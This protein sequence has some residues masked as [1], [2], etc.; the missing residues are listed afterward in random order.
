MGGVTS[1]V[2]VSGA[3]KSRDFQATPCVPLVVDLDGTLIKS[4]LLLETASQFA[5]AW[6]SRAHKLAAWL[7][8]GKTVL[9]TNLAQNTRLDFTS[10][11]Y[12]EELLAWL[13]Q[14]KAQGRVIV[15]ATA[16]D[17]LLANRVASHLGLFSEVLASDL[18]TNLKATAKCAA[19]VAK[20]GR[21]GF[22]YV[23]NDWADIEVWKSAAQAHVVSRSGR[24]IK[25]ASS[26]APLG[27]IFSDGKPPV[28]L[29]L[30]QALRPQQW[31]KNL[32][33][34]I[35]LLTA[36]LYSDAGS[37][38]QALLGSTAFCLTASSAYLLNDMVDVAHDRKHA[39]KRHRPFAAGHLSLLYGWLAWPMLLISAF[40]LSQAALPRP[41]TLS[42]GVYFVLT[43]A[44]SLHLKTIPMVDVLMLASLYTLRIIAGAMAIGVPL[45]FW[46][47]SFSMFLFLSLAL[48]KRNGE[49]RAVSQ[50]GKSKNVNGRGYDRDDLELVR[51]L[52]VSA[53]Y[54]S[55][56][57]L[58]LYVQDTHTASLYNTPQFLWLAC[59]LLLFW[60][61][62]AWLISHRGQMHDDP[63]VFAL[64][65][66]ISWMVAALSIVAFVMGKIAA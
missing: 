64:K 51:D 24:L 19:L 40:I 28:M 10:L 33:V 6:P 39:R 23:G 38:L 57:V 20:Y 22:E 49:L 15:L 55:V 3:G 9:K 56:L 17:G 41:F 65:D 29:A 21:K 8:Q 45:T 61:S 54:A 62:R 12:N 44:Y 5:L 7:A 66:G 43:L 42:L 37:V 59:P 27:E 50:Q 11:P 32:L 53:G 18:T 31:I 52:G 63:I 48:I 58:A 60:I 36:H 14:E 4:D 30:L 26:L 16:S 46:L 35:P 47:L 34:L 2:G 1:Q 25:V 13:K